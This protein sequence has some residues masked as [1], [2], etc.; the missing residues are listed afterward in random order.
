MAWDVVTTA[1]IEIFRYSQIF[2]KDVARFG[3]LLNI[4]EVSK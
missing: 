4:K 3:R 1:A 2:P